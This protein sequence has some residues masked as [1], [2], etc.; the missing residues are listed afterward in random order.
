MKVSLTLGF[1][2]IG[3]VYTFLFRIKSSCQRRELE[4]QTNLSQDIEVLSFRTI[5][6]MLYTGGRIDTPEGGH[7][8]GSSVRCCGLA[9]RRRNSYAGACVQVLPSSQWATGVRC[10]EATT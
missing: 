7:S 2:R 10:L 9:S 4:L 6:H 1:F 8:N 5:G 3:S